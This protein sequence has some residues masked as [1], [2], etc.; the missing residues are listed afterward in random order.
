MNIKK[1]TLITLLTLTPL[2]SHS[3]DVMRTAKKAW[4]SNWVKMGSCAALCG[5]GYAMH[6]LYH[7]NPKLFWG[8]TS[9]MSALASCS[10]LYADFTNYSHGKTSTKPN[11]PSAV[12]LDDDFFDFSAEDI[13]PIATPVV[14]QKSAEPQP[15]QPMV[16]EPIM[17]ITETSAMQD[18]T[19]PE[20]VSTQALTAKDAI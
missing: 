10:C 15:E 13:Q 16:A 11:K 19:L 3:N 7:T 18:L 2:M 12:S 14:Q 17:E 8:I 6:H 5:S 9:V 20:A 1:I 4:K